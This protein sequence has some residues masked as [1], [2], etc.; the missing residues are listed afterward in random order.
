MLDGYFYNKVYFYFYLPLLGKLYL[1]I[2]IGII[3]SFA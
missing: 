2:S 1:K 3:T